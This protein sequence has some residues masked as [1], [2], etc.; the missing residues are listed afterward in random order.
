MKNA[1]PALINFLLNASSYARVD[2][3]TITL[4]GGTVLRYSSAPGLI[5]ANGFN[6]GTGPIV[7]DG[8][9]KSARGLDVSEL[10]ITIYAGDSHLV[11][12]VQFLDFVENLGLDGALIKVERGFAADWLTMRSSGPIGTYIRFSGRF[13]EAKEMGFT[14]VVIT[15]ASPLDSFTN[16]TPPDVYQTSC[17]NVLGDAKC[18]INLASFAV[19]GIVAASPAPTSNTFGSNLTPVANDYG[20]GKVI[21]T[22]GANNGLSF[23]VKTNDAS[24]NF[25]LAIAPPTAPAAGDHF[26]AY[27]GCDLSTTRCTNK[28]NNLIHYRG[29]PFIPD[30]STGLPS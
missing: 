17:A 1:S 11:N 20:L 24:G 19:N 10:D 22:S 28:F 16:N 3:Y 4:N 25:V 13:S 18:M 5:L 14:Q 15:A 6:F 2:F 12:G 26:T 29:Q 23:T 21:F 9:V 30:P 8:G 27:P 7:Q